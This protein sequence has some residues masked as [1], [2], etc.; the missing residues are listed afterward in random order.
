MDKE[1]MLQFVEL[2][3]LGLVNIRGRNCAKFVAS[4]TRQTRAGKLDLALFDVNDFDY[5]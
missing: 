4:H 2:T 5:A 3:C 1:V